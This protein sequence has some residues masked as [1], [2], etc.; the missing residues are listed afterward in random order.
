M[1][2]DVTPMVKNLLIIN[3]GIF[4]FA[5][6]V[7][8]QFNIDINEFFGVHSLYSEKFG[9]W[10]FVTYMFM[11]AYWTG[12]GI[13]F[14]H[15]LYNMFAL[16]TFGPMLERYWGT[17]RFLFFYLFTGIGAG[18]LYWGINMYETYEL[19]KNVDTYVSNPNPDNFVQFMKDND[20]SAYENNISFIDDFSNNP[21]SAELV[22]ATKTYAKDLFTSRAAF[23]MVG[24]SGA[25]FGI[26]M[27]FGLLFPNTELMLL[28]PPIPI[29]AKYI[30]AFYGL[31]E[32]YMEYNQSAGDNVAHFAHLAGMLFGFILVKYW[33]KQRNSFY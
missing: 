2:F 28:F 22:T 4:I 17:K 27:A 19:K 26:L 18:M 1:R 30:V 16:F 7:F 21:G 11:H 14:S 9:P 31:F 32:L 24:A 8:K 6:F 13:Y 3:I 15:V 10:Q 29:K 5:I 12:N 23:S 25:I 33:Q 20:K